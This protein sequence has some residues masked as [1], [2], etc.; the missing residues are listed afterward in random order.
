MRTL[1]R[2]NQ[3]ESECRPSWRSARAGRGS[4]PGSDGLRGSRTPGR[5]AGRREGRGPEPGHVQAVRSVCGHP[6]STP[7]ALQIR[8]S[9]THLEMEGSETTSS[10]EASKAGRGA[11][12]ISQDPSP[13]AG[14]LLTREMGPKSNPRV[15]RPQNQRVVLSPRSLP[16]TRMCSL[17]AWGQ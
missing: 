1:R 11:A 4:A 16:P 17:R 2:Q 12:P 6:V 8:G 3:P 13:R 7:T 10:Q 9:C 5:W 14:C 15:A